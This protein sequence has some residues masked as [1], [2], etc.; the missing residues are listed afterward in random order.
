MNNSVS[1]LIALTG[2]LCLAGCGDTSS[3][4]ASTSSTLAATS[5][6]SAA[7]QSPVASNSS[8]YTLNSSA[9]VFEAEDNPD[10]PGATGR[11]IVPGDNS[12]IAGDMAATELQRT[13]AIGR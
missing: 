13:G 5:S 12:T 10:V 8:P 11:A 4:S 2:I 6:P 3:P 7:A 9:T 1:T